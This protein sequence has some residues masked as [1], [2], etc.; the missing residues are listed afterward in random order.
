MRTPATAGTT[1]GWRPSRPTRARSRQGPWCRR[2]CVEDAAGFE[3]SYVDYIGVHRRARGR[4]VAKAL[5]HTAIAEAAQAGTQPGGPRGRRRLADRVPTACTPRWA[6]SPTT[7]PSRGTASSTCAERPLRDEGSSPTRC[8]PPAGW[9]LRSN[10]TRNGRLLSRTPDEGLAHGLEAAVD[11]LGL[12]HHGA[13]RT[14]RRRRRCP[15]AVRSTAGC[16]PS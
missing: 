3:G 15:V 1:G 2:C 13:G 5:L 16:P 7:A 6:G 10:V 8:R 14:R 11:R 9:G 4:G 12:G